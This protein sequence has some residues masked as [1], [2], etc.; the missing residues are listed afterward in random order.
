MALL[1]AKDAS[2][3]FSVFYM[4][5]HFQLFFADSNVQVIPEFYFALVWPVK[6]MK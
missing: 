1:T 2:H 3:A 6:F 5:F 4:Y